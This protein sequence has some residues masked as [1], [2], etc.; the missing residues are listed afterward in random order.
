ML[1]RSSSAADS[2]RTQSTWHFSTRGQSRCLYE[3]QPLRIAALRMI[4][5][6]VQRTGAKGARQICAPGRNRAMRRLSEFS[7]ICRESAIHQSTT[8]SQTVS[9][10]GWQRERKLK[11]DNSPYC[12]QG[13]ATRRGEGWRDL[14]LVLVWP[15]EEPAFLRRIAQ[16]IGLLA[17]GLDGRRR[18]KSV[19]LL[20]QAHKEQPALRRISQGAVRGGLFRCVFASVYQ[21][22]LLNF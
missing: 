21:T 20:L 17:H 6:A 7:I 8:P 2:L 22:S 3:D 12:R 18:Q 19:F 10:I 5:G 4:I 9:Q 11:H 1:F 14:L 16:G 13:T 15:I